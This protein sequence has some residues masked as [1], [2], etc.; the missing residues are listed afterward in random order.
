MKSGK[1]SLIHAGTLV[2]A[3]AAALT[4]EFRYDFSGM[5]DAAPDKI[6]HFYAG[7]FIALT[8]F[9]G[10]YAI[11]VGHLLITR[12]RQMTYTLLWLPSLIFVATAAVGA[13]VILAAGGKEALD[14]GNFD[15]ADFVATLGGAWTMAPVIGLV[16]AATPLLIPIDVFIKT[17]AFR[18]LADTGFSVID[19]FVRIKRRHAGKEAWQN[20]SDVLLLE[21]DIEYAAVVLE[22]LGAF[23]LS[24]RHEYGIEA[25]RSY[26]A[27]N[28]STLKAVI[29]DVYV[30]IGP[31]SD[32]RTG[33][34][35]LVELARERA[36]RGAG[37]KL[38]AC[39]AH[40]EALGAR[41]ELADAVI[42]KPWRHVRE[43]ELFAGLKLL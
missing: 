19:R 43:R 39:T 9:L 10:V 37:P 14:H 26:C 41:A 13:V 8:L 25:A 35:W 42:E 27:E 2:C 40:P 30:R 22:S 29:I 31:E 12:G 32:L 7:R 1:R 4:L 3:V 21:D 16:M 28:W 17:R 36:A 11:I 15:V 24:C 18:R 38:I 5:A 23:G 6:R 34:E 20:R 33:A